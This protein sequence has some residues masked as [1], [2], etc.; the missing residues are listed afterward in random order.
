[1]GQVRAL[2]VTDTGTRRG[3]HRSTGPSKRPGN[4][5][6][7]GA[8]S[9]VREP[10]LVDAV[11][12]P[13]HHGGTAARADG[14]AAVGVVNIAGVDE[15]QPV[16]LRDLPGP[17]QCGRRRRRNVAHLEIGVKRGEVQRDVDAE[18]VRDPRALGVDLGVGVVVP[19]NQ[20]RG[21]LEPH[22]GLPPQVHQGVQHRPQMRRAGAA[23]EVVGER[24]EVHV[25]RVEV[26]EQLTPWRVGQVARR[27]RHRLDPPGSAGICDV[28]R[29]L[30]ED[31]RVVVG[32]RHAATPQAH[33]SLGD[34]VRAGSLRQPVDLPRLGDV[35]VL[36][37]PARQVAARGS[38]G[39]HRAAGQEVIERLLLDRIHAEPARPTVR[40]QHD[41]VSHPAPNEAQAPLALVQPTG[42]RAYIALHPA[43]VQLMPVPARHR[44]SIFETDLG[45][46]NG[47]RTTRYPLEGRAEPDSAGPGAKPSGRVRSYRDQARLDAGSVTR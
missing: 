42:P 27:H 29:V 17:A 34:V 1:M 43:V 25:R 28:D 11:P 41:L 44:I 46:H 14:P 37:E 33:G 6:A 2:A 31:H 18:V 45:T 38:E 26:G 7:A 8:A 39:Q 4:A 20:Q 5:S 13:F 32:H 21:D 24:L 22:V 47:L 19:G 35:P 12:V 36:A 23:V 10:V 40:G 15:P 9:V 30:Q 16:S 3:P